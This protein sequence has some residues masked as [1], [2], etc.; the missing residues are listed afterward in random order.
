MRVAWELTGGN[1]DWYWA[2][3]APSIVT[4]GPALR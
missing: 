3:D 2:V 4:S 1:N